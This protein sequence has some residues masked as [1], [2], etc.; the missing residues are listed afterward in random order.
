[1]VQMTN[2]S[3]IIQK[4]R[5]KW[6]GHLLRMD[7]NTS[8]SVALKLSMKTNGKKLRGNHITWIKQANQDLKLIQQDFSIEDSRLQEMVQHRSIWFSKVEEVVRV[9]CITNA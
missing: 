1:M 6:L 3:K 5:L 8:A 7:E 9:S 2:W 4:R